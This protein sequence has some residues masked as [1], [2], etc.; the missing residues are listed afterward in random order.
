[1]QKQCTSCGSTF[2]ITESDSA[3]LN[4]IAASALEL[5]SLPQPA[6]CPDCRQQRRLARR[7]ERS[8]HR[9]TCSLCKKKILS[10]YNEAASFPVYCYECWWSDKW[11][12]LSFGKE[13]DFSRP[14]FDQFLELQNTVPRINLFGK[15]NENCEYVNHV[16]N[17]QNCYLCVDTVARDTYYSKWMIECA[18]CCD[19]YQLEKSEVCHESQYSVNLHNSIYSFLC[20][21]SSNLAFCYDCEDCHDCFLC[22]HLRHKKYCIGNEQLSEEEYKQKMKEWDFSSYM[23]FQKALSQYLSMWKQTFHRCQHIIFSEDSTGDF[24]YHCNNVKNSFGVIESQDCSYCYDAGFMKDCMD[25]YEP[26]FNCELQYDSHGCN[27]G[28]RQMGCHI[29]YDNDSLAYCDFCHN[30]SNLFGCI[31]LKRKQYCILNKQYSKEDYTDLLPKIIE[32]MKETGEWGNFFPIQLSP[33]AYNETTAQEYYP[34]SAEQALQKGYEWNKHEDTPQVEKVI[35]ADQLPDSNKDIPDDVLNWAVKCSETQRPFRLT[36]QELAFYR[37]NNIAI[38]R[39]HPDERHKRRMA[40]TNPRKLNSRS[41]SKCN[42]DI[43]TTYKTEQSEQVY[44]EECY[45]SEIY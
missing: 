26:A 17:S 3:L 8:F 13:Y 24:I 1:M 5:S 18:D 27:G 35:S 9:V 19:C 12:C 2:K 10:M 11:D 43:Q 20:D 25:A 29:C 39:L 33:F 21:Q 36:K 15:N 4:K 31:G 7:N 34:L 44:C 6:N 41:C 32:H 23:S 30:S 28:K 37:Q 16:V 42:K 45:L 14:F 22:S 40:F 38:P